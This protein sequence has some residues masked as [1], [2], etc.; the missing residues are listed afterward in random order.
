MCRGTK[1][2]KDP[3]YPT[4]LTEIGVQFDSRWLQQ[5]NCEEVLLEALGMLILAT[6]LLLGSPG[7][8]PLALAAV[9]A[10][11]GSARGV[12]FLLGILSGLA[13]AITLGS[14]GINALFNAFPQA[15]FVVS[16]LGGAYICYIAFKIASAPIVSADKARGAEPPT[17]RDGFIMNLLNPKAYAAFVALFSQ[18]LLP[19]DGGTTSA[20]AT[21]AVAFAVAII[22]DVMWLVLGGLLAPVFESPR[23]ARPVRI[24]FGAM[25]VTAVLI[26]LL[27][28]A[29][30]VR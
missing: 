4:D 2:A 20:A 10:V 22:V 28:A 3:C 8:V 17:F 26:A 30:W 9:G 29:T 11:F 14:L 12:P 7:P 23:F 5:A 19:L 16:A 18:F 21:A 27:T 15:R 13:V 25:M 24:A 1:Y 6:A